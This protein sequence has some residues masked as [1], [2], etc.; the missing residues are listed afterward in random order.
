MPKSMQDTQELMLHELR[1]VLYAEKAI[2]KMLPKL[3]K[4]ASDEELREGFKQHLEQTK[5]QI[6]NLEQVF[7]HLGQAAR[8]KKCPGIEGIK[9][10]HDEFIESESPSAEICDLFLTGAGAR[11]EHYEIAAYKG[12]VTMARALGEEECAGLLEENLQQEQETLEKL[13]SISE[14]LAMAGA[15]SRPQPM[16]L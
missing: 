8:A 16:S 4:E 3:A 7:D 12:L 6:S 5:G 14:R 9:A 11:T 2:V 1:D 15:A 13:E 10:E